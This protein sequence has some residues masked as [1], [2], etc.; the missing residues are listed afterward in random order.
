MK[1]VS[2]KTNILPLKDIPVGGVF[3][4][5]DCKRY[6]LRTDQ[7]RDEDMIRVVSLETGEIY[8]FEAE[9]EVYLANAHVVVEN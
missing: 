3:Y 1:I 5:E 2:N 7:W 8:I 4:R 6:Y 9:L